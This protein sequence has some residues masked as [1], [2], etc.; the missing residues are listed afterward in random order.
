MPITD[1]RSHIVESAGTWKDSVSLA[2]QA[3]FPFTLA[4]TFSPARLMLRWPGDAVTVAGPVRLR[5]TFQS[6]DVT[7]EMGAMMAAAVGTSL[8]GS[9]A[10]LLG[11]SGT[12]LSLVGAGTLQA[13]TMYS[14]LLDV[15][16][17][18][19]WPFVFK[20]PNVIAGGVGAFYD[21]VLIEWAGLDRLA[22]PV[23][24]DCDLPCDFA[25]L[26][27]E[28][29][30]AFFPVACE[31]CAPG[32]LMRM[33]PLAP[34]LSVPS[35]E[36]GCVRT[37]FFNGMFIT[38]E[39]LETEQR[40]FRIKN[41]LQN[42]A[43]GQGVVWGL[44]VG[45]SGENVCVLPG[46]AVDCCGN[47]LTVTTPY[48]VDIA[49]LLRDPAGCLTGDGRPR[50]M[51][52]LLEY[53]E[54]PAEPR[55]VHNDPCAPS[56]LACEPSRV[57]ETV[58]LRLV[59]P[60]PPS[61]T[62][63]VADFLSTAEALHEKYGSRLETVSQAPAV[64]EV[65]LRVRS[66]DREMSIAPGEPPQNIPLP[67]APILLTAEASGEPAAVFT[68]GTLRVRDSDG[69][70]RASAPLALLSLPGGTGMSLPVEPVAG[71]T[72]A[73]D[74]WRV[75]S[76]VAAE[77]GWA[78]TGDATFELRTTEQIAQ[79]AVLS[80]E[81]R[82]VTP[83][84][85]S[86]C[87]EPCVV[88]PTREQEEEECKPMPRRRSS[89]AGIRWPWLHRDPLATGRA[90][91]PKALAMG[92]LEAWLRSASASA[93][94]PGVQAPWSFSKLAASTLHRAAW[95][96]FYGVDADQDKREVGDAL[97]K[98][99]GGWCASMIY[100][101]PSCECEPHGVV[102][103]CTTVQ[104][105]RMGEIDPFGGRR[106]VVHWPLV[107]YWGEQAGI[108]PLELSATR[109][110]STM[111][112]LAALPRPAVAGRAPALLRRVGSRDEDGAAAY[113][114]FGT[115]KG[116]A[117]AW[118]QQTG[119]DLRVAASYRVTVPRFSALVASALQGRPI[120]AGQSQGEQGALIVERFTVGG[121]VEPGVVSLLVSRR[122]P[123]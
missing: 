73:F 18:Q 67:D 66:G 28:D 39:D 123:G 24:A 99:L 104:A 45:R 115:E 68:A 11:A 116:V 103:G 47:D 93:A 50:Q 21:R 122:V 43:A 17:G 88:H 76:P 42:R 52:L 74:G 59:P 37:R 1:L 89:G 82:R 8:S 30:G 16:A 96:L 77:P 65:R 15:P 56:E 86:V 13:S 48:Q 108:A 23:A 61:T 95:L 14:Y 25:V 113:L 111:C 94:E 40:Y 101:G 120:S 70:E 97:Q 91:D 105:G 112:C 38:K 3:P 4:D 92:I 57:R 22:E 121:L 106:Y 85:R 63:P 49:S 34:A 29:S 58:R 84:R 107:S 119:E 6:E 62:G 114:A 31:P 27:C 72:V 19:V 60:R 100:P 87:G 36:G 75:E 35:A 64:I 5:V 53:V 41:R 20:G 12:G 79:I 44:D 51:A 78:E 110:F 7:Y 54:C 71:Y 46:Y 81:S 98:L 26:D 80:S 83:D 90:G 10:T 9:P 55:P 32:A 102:I 69:A 2:Q 117:S 118:A 109:L 33:P